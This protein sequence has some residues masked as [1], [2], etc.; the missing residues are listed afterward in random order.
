ML[1]AVREAISTTEAPLTVKGWSPDTLSDQTTCTN[2]GTNPQTPVSDQF[3]LSHSFNADFSPHEL[4]QRSAPLFSSLSRPPHKA[5]AGR[6]RKTRQRDLENLKGWQVK[7]LH[8]ADA[9]ADSLGLGMD[10]FVTITPLHISTFQIGLK[11]AGQWLRDHGH[12]FVYIYVHENPGGYRPH[13]HLLIHIPLGLIKPFVAR[14]ADWFAGTNE[15]DIRVEPRTMLGW[16]R[17]IRVRYMTKGARYLACAAYEGHRK[18]GGQG[19]IEFKRSGVCQ[20][21]RN[22]FGGIHDTW[23]EPIWKKA[24]K[25]KMLMSGDELKA[26][27]GQFGLSQTELA[28]LAG[29]HRNSVNRLENMDLIRP[30]SRHAV[31][32]I[33]NAMG[34]RTPEAYR[35]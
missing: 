18:K 5:S 6:S 4:P 26:L 3:V 17:A 29:L 20:Y 2:A 8:H 14:M 28:G 22:Q 35:G 27:R 25:L 9:I 13:T 33:M 23:R 10:W 15:T 1:N 12:P 21:L 30:T 19:P 24:R 34:V 32:R 16:S 31:C 11:R 7:D